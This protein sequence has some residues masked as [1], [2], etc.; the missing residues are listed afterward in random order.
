MD[1]RGETASG[2]RTIISSFVLLFK[3]NVE[4][5]IATIPSGTYASNYHLADGVVTPILGH[6]LAPSPEA[7]TPASFSVIQGD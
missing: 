1:S 3:L 7:P 4:S 2:E 6:P 5:S